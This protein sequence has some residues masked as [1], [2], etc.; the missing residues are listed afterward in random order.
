MNTQILIDKIIEREQVAFRNKFIIMTR[1]TK[2]STLRNPKDFIDNAFR[3]V[4]IQEEH[5][6]P[7][8]ADFVD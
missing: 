5:S 4:G 6:N 1:D 3:F 8:I 7:Y 2:M